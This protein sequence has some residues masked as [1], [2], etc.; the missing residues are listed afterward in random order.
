MCGWVRAHTECRDG[1]AAAAEGPGMTCT[2]TLAAFTAAM[3]HTLRKKKRLLFP[4]RSGF[5]K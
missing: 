5:E 4:I 1:K 2:R 3:G